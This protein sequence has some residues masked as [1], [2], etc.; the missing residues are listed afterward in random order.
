M[1][2]AR[3][4]RFAAVVIQSKIRVEIK[5]KAQGKMQNGIA[6]MLSVIRSAIA[7]WMTRASSPIRIAVAVQVGGGNRAGMAPTVYAAEKFKRPFPAP[8]KSNSI[9]TKSSLAGRRVRQSLFDL[10][11]E[12]ESEDL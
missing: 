1:I 10:V 5:H 8:G 6:S 2:I 7:E 4:S 9:V 3:D 12:L 11:F